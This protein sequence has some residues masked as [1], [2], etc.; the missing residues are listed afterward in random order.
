MPSANRRPR[1]AP[2]T[3]VDLP[4]ELWELVLRDMPKPQ[5]WKIRSLNRRVYSC[6]ARARYGSIYLT[7]R[8]KTSRSTN[9]VLERICDST[10]PIAGLVHTIHLHSDLKAYENPKDLP[11]HSTGRAILLD[12]DILLNPDIKLL[13][14]TIHRAQW[15]VRPYVS[16]AW[17]TFANTLVHLELQFFSPSVLH[18]IPENVY[19][20]NL[21]T[22]VLTYGR[23]VWP[24]AI[25]PPHILDL[26]A[27][28]PYSEVNDSLI[29][30]MFSALKT[31]LPRELESLG[32]HSFSYSHGFWNLDRSFLHPY[33]TFPHLKGLHISAFSVGDDTAMLPFLRFHVG[34]LESFRLTTFTSQTQSLL[35]DLPISS[36]LQELF[37]T[38]KVFC[39]IF[40]LDLESRK[41]S[42][43]IQRCTSLR[44]LIIG[45]GLG[46]NEAFHLIVELARGG[47]R[48]EELELNIPYVYLSLFRAAHLLLPHLANLTFS[49]I[50]Q[51][52]WRDI[53]N[54]STR[55]N[56]WRTQL[57][58]STHITYRLIGLGKTASRLCREVR[59]AMT[60]ALREDIDGFYETCLWTKAEQHELFSAL[61]KA[62]NGAKAQAKPDL[63]LNVA[64][65]NHQ[66]ATMQVVESC[67]VDLDTK[68]YPSR[69]T[70]LS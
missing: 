20:V 19:C 64:A 41:A 5:L 44:R 39:D 11:Q 7:P 23:S 62:L 67:L 6:A 25:H 58:Y 40:S 12:K 66:W 33:T 10:L 51:T 8:N 30:K 27:K 45:E 1:R 60:K 34:Q 42:R 13:N 15:W 57:C 36:N 9:D 59:Q 52:A 49:H 61:K 54:S 47:S 68:M 29:S 50:R 48:V 55:P 63:C 24:G 21:K 22:F 2:G 3:G 70:D 31:I 32:L 14:L 69:W 65:R 18:A 46:P 16:L 35:R 26:E 38:Y 53:L 4:F 37:L 28:M 43:I 56:F 17:R